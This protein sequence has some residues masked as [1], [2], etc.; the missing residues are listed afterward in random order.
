[1]TTYVKVRKSDNAI[2]KQKEYD[3]PNRDLQKDEVW[4]PLVED[5]TQ[6][7][8]VDLKLHK[9]VREFRF[10]DLSGDLEDAV[11]THGLKKVDLSNVEKLIVLDAALNEKLLNGES[12]TD[13]EIAERKALVDS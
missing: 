2:L 5:N 6:P 7:D 1:M 12:L 11:V 9:V 13:D 8:D 3:N 10:P 4:L